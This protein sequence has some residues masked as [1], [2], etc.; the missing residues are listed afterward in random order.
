SGTSGNLV[1]KVQSKGLSLLAPTLTVYDA[2]QCQKVFISGAG[3][4]GTTLSTTLTG[5]SAGLVYYVVVDNADNSAFGTGAYFLG[6]NFGAGT[7]P[8][9][10][11]PSTATLNG[12][13]FTSGG[14][15]PTKVG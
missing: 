4:Y 13:P 1:V 10:T 14:G 15:Q 12:N 3:Q 6:L 8:S 7:T 5:V 11:P 2:N 9:A